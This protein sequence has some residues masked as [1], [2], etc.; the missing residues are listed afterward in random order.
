MAGVAK[1]QLRWESLPPNVQDITVFVPAIVRLL[2]S[3]FLRSE[4][5]KHEKIGATEYRVRRGLVE[6]LAIHVW[7]QEHVNVSITPSSRMASFLPVVAGVLSAL[8]TN[9]A[10]DLLVERIGYDIDGP[11]HRQQ[12][13]SYAL[14]FSI[15]PI[16]WL[17]CWGALGML[18]KVITGTTAPE[19]LEQSLMADVR[20]MLPESVQVVEP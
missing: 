7:R 1:L 4:G 13:T 19:I 20:R 11:D 9:L 15:W 8:L 2:E 6:G 17:L 3:R 14:V 18:T 16:L 10:L 12:A 5:W